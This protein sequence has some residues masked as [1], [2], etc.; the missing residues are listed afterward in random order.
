[1][2]LQADPFAARHFR[3]VLDGKDQH[4]AILTDHGEMV[5]GIIDKYAKSCLGRRLDV[6][7][8]LA[9][10]RRGDAFSLRHNKAVARR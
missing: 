2:L 9:F 10:A 5:G 6:Q 4:L 8:L 3:N 7:H 1:M